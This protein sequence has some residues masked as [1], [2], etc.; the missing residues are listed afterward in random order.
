VVALHPDLVVVNDEENRLEDAAGLT[1]AGLRVHSMSP[2]SVAEVG[3]A[4][5]A[6]CHVLGRAV[7]DEF[8]HAAWQQWL[9]ERR[10]A[11]A[12]PP[13]R[14]AVVMVWRR[15]WMTLAADTYGSS[16]LELLGIDNAFGSSVGGERYPEVTLDEIAARSPDVVL[17][18][19]EPYPFR[20]PHAEEISTVLAPARVTIVDGQDLF[21][22]G[23]RTPTAIARLE[24][25][26]RS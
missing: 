14:T 25:M 10:A 8:V 4:I 22:W 12:A 2:R 26:L 17:L 18:P 16:V 23:I 24:P 11:S 19:D 15:P 21:W 6:L 3:P 20:A 5:V 13:R 9:T 7:P 1:G